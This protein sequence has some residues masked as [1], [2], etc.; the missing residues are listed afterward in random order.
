MELIFISPVARGLSAADII[1]S[2]LS[3]PKLRGGEKIFRLL[4]RYRL[5]NLHSLLTFANPPGPTGQHVGDGHPRDVV[6]FGQLSQKG[7]TP[8]MRSIGFE[9]TTDEQM[10]RR[11]IESAQEFKPKFPRW[12]AV[13]T[14]LDC[15][16]STA[17][18]LC[19]RFNL[20][21]LEKTR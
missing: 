15:N 6:F 17:R 14:I 9:S 4:F 20:N 10:L 18:A 21:P 2:A 12:L 16:C 3:T 19:E 7:D 1:L 5:K 8:M 11:F 13:A